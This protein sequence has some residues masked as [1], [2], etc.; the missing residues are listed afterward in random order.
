MK[1]N[2]LI[3]LILMSVLLAAGAYGIWYS[4]VTGQAVYDITSSTTPITILA[5]FDSAILMNTSLGAVQANHSMI[6]DNGDGPLP[7]DM[8]VIITKVDTADGCTDYSNDTVIRL[9]VNGQEEQ[10]I[11]SGT[12][13]A[14]NTQVLLTAD[15]LKYSC[16]GSITANVTVST[17]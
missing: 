15:S 7:Y 11:H 5:G 8:T 1:K 3:G 14:G 6:L 2:Q 9:F 12:L 13:P 10:F 16:P 4:T 17:I